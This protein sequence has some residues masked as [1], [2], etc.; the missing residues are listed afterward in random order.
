MRPLAG[1]LLLC[2]GAALPSACGG[3]TPTPSPRP[4][5]GAHDLAPAASPTP[6]VSAA[7]RTDSWPLLPTLA[8]LVQRLERA[9]Q[10]L[11]AVREAAD[12]EEAHAAARW[13]LDLLVGPGGRHAGPFTLSPGVLP[14]DG[15]AVSDP[16]LALAAYDAASDPAVR[17]A[18]E[19]VLLG[20]VDRWRQPARRWDEMDAA[21]AAWTPRDNSV[22][23]LD[24]HLPR[25]VCWTALILDAPSL[26]RAQEY[27][28]HGAL[29][30]DLSLQAARQALAAA[31]ASPPQ[32]EHAP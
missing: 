22:A 14:A 27:A 5:A 17:E 9:D 32:D 8:V 16:G 13:A 26:A 30:L 2:L 11:A 24:G 29:H 3:A 4:A 20:D 6:R 7:W 19:R 21:I 10:A 23:S 12:L 1:L 28:S 15:E 31:A 25:V 18:I